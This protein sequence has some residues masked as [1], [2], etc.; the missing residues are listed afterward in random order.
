MSAPV[1][2]TP[3]RTGDPRTRGKLVV[4]ER[5]LEK[6]AGQAASEVTT[7]SGRSGGFLGIGAES[8]TNARPKVEATLNDRSAD[9]SVAVGIAYPGS[10]RRATTELREHLTR[11]VEALT[12][13]AVHRVDVDVT[14]L[15]LQDGTTREALR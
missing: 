5:V 12:G 2:G 13:F 7:V 15:P 14:V 3:S 1:T 11:R 9:L 10:I 6:I 8:D 4:A